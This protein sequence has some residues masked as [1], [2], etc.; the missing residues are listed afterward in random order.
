MEG[1]LWADKKYEGRGDIEAGIVTE[2]FR[3]LTTKMSSWEVT[4]D[5]FHQLVGIDNQQGR[6]T[7]GSNDTEYRIQNC[8]YYVSRP[9]VYERLYSKVNE[10]PDLVS[11]SRR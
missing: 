2:D 1:S 11:R 4:K 8:E 10:L 3:L 9:K 5:G 6:G 7:Y